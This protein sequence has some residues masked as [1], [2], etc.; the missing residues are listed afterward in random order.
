MPRKR[1]EDSVTEAEVIHMEE[2]VKEAE[3]TVPQTTRNAQ[4]VA[5]PQEGKGL[6]LDD[7][8]VGYVVGLTEEGNF[9]FELFGKDP[10][11][12]ELLGVHQHAVNRVQ[13]IY[14]D[15]QISGDRLIHEVG[16]AV[17]MLNQKLDQVLQAVAPKE[18][19]NRIVKP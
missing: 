7:L 9:V 18:P 14:D 4:E 5:Q 11:L 13:R 6:T 2:A 19:D 15:K 10:G 16:K 12:V 17:A 8:K 1:K 3:E